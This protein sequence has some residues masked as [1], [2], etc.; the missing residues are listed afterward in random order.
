MK[1]GMLE[2]TKKGNELIYKLY[3]EGKSVSEIGK[4]LHLDK[5]SV[6]RRFKNDKTLSGLMEG[7]KGNRLS[8]GKMLFE[9]RKQI[10]SMITEGMSFE[11]ISQVLNCKAAALRYWV[12]QKRI[13]FKASWEE[14][15]RK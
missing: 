6:F 5:S 13:L 7:R 8:V 10:K 1:R 14:V 15:M 9:N 12:Y 4:I 3:A 11:Q 2:R